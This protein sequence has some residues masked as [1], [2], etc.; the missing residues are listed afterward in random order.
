MPGP[1]WHVPFD[2]MSGFVGRTD[3][4]KRLKQKIFETDSRRVI[5]ILGL[6]GV[7]KSRL[8]LEL[9]YQIQSEHPRHSIFWIQAA[10]QLTFEKDV[11][12]IGKKLKI[13]GIEDD[14]ADIKN[15]VKQRL[16]NPSEDKWFLIL[17]NADNEELWGKQSDSSQHEFSLVEYLPRTTNGSILITT[18]ARSVAS[19][20][21]GKDVIELRAMS[22]DE[23]TEMFA[24]RLEAADLAADQ[25]TLLTLLDKLAY[26]PLAIVQA[27]SFINMT[28]RP[29][30]TYLELLDQSE[31]DV[32]KLLSKDFGD[33]SRYPNAKNPVATTWLISFDHVRKHHQLAG[34]LL[35]C[36]ACFHNKNIPLSLLPETGSRID[37]IDAVAVLTGYSFVVRRQTGSSGV[38]DLEELYDMHRL[39]QLAARNWLKIKGSLAD[40]TT[41]CITRMAQLFPT[42]DHQHKSTWTLYL[43]HAQRL[44]AESCVEELSERYDLLEK[45]GLCSVVDGK[46]DEAVKI[47][48]V[49]VQWR[50]QELGTSE[51]KTLRAYSNLGEALD[52]RGNRSVAQR[53]LQQALKWQKETLG[54]E[55]HSTLTSMVNLAST[56][57][58][59]GRW[60]EAEELEVQVMETRK[61]VLGTEHPGTLTSM[62]NL[63][64]TF[65]NQGRWKKAEELFMQVMETRKRVLGTKHPDTLISMANLA[66]T[67][68]NQG[69]WK[70]AEELEV[71]VV[72]TSS[73]V[74]GMEHPDTLTSMDNLASTFWNQGRWK[75]A[76]E[77]FMQVMD[78]SSRVLG[79][80]H[81][82]TLTSMANL[83]SKYQNQGR[84]KEAEELDVQVMGMSSRVLGTEHPDTLTSMNNLAYALKHQNNDDEAIELMTSCMELCV[85]VL[86]PSH[87]HTQSVFMTLMAWLSA[88]R[89]RG[90]EGEQ[91]TSR[92]PGAWVD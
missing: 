38:T 32:I 46:Y 22:S 18:R 65:W 70:E 84:W 27:A 20:L 89:V 56:Y 8:A 25:T 66:S 76:E 71:Q 5:S 6:G 37:I 77:L 3:E 15:L 57:R 13:P 24:N 30:R 58:N 52:W 33:P 69:R 7:G 59:Q 41:A 50:E 75:D 4:L 17:D 31:V 62:N 81:P 83:A 1:V 10:E 68:R 88:S 79:T 78:T 43:P 21:A 73:R 34:S 12:E 49:V 72:E 44:C 9:A 90:Q 60:K 51:Q 64:S 42:R 61:R 2:R 87:H 85:K 26:L 16:S 67:Y 28:Q 23:A 40:W 55:H 14:K 63:A 36:M 82:S 74:L 29:V 48:T 11:L 47:H 54:Q 35:S 39:V 53:Y 91:S 45:M 80:E 86:G 19:F 92:M